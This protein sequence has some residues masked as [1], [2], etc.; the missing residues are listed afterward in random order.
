MHTCKQCNSHFNKLGN[1]KYNQYNVKCKFQVSYIHLDRRKILKYVRGKY[2]FIHQI[3][4]RKRFFSFWMPFILEGGRGSVASEPT[5][6]EGSVHCSEKEQCKFWAFMQFQILH[7][8][9]F[10]RHHLTFI[11]LFFSF[12]T[13]WFS[14]R[15]YI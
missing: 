12:K 13:F 5:G 6:S 8:D 11:A 2:I 10:S 9:L 1:Q 4:W 7:S 15:K 3:L 14:E